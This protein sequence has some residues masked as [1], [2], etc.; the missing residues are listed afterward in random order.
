MGD[1]VNPLTMSGHAPKDKPQE[2]VLLSRA[3]PLPSSTLFGRL[4]GHAGGRL[5]PHLQPH[6][7]SSSRRSGDTGTAV[8]LQRALDTGLVDASGLSC[9]TCPNRTA[10][11]PASPAC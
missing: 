4:Q 6:L 11:S 1:L 10:P 5:R 3:E 2:R 8:P 9:L 7:P